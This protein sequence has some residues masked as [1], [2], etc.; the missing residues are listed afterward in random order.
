[1]WHGYSQ[2][3]TVTALVSGK[4]PSIREAAPW[5]SST[6]EQIIM[7]AIAAKREDRYPTALDLQVDLENNLAEL[8]GVVQQRELATFMKT[9]FSDM[10]AERQRLVETEARKAPVALTAVLQQ[11]TAVSPLSM[12]PSGQSGSLQMVEGQARRRRR[13]PWVIAL[14]LAGAIALGIGLKTRLHAIV[15]G[16]SASKPQA[17]AERLVTLAVAAWPVEAKVLLDGEPA[18]AN[19]WSQRFPVSDRKVRV[20]VTAPGHRTFTQDVAL[21]ADASLSVQLEAQPAAE[22][23]AASPTLPAS[24]G[25]PAPKTKRVSALTPAKAPAAAPAAATPKPNCTPPYVLDAEGVKT[26]KPECL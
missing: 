23:P 5:I 7:R 12:T 19:P 10:R 21:N 22:P 1:M 24:A 18:S 13:A 8:G 16:P 6:W 2:N 11:K 25:K 20:E 15:A 17:P 14:G 3:Q 9:E 4:L 26:Y